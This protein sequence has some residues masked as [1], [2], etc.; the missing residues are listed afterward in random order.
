VNI[1]FDFCKKISFL[2]STNPLFLNTPIDSTPIA[3]KI[4]LWGEHSLMLGS[5]ALALPLPVF[6]GAWQL[7]G[8]RNQQYQLLE[9]VN[10]L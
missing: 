9:F 10:R 7:H 4:L 1:F 2:I 3:A 8:S 6:G 5:A